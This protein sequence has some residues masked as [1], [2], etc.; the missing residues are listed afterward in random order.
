MQF[1]LLIKGGEV[2]DPGSDRRGQLDVA[3]KR[4]R[5][6]A[7]EA[8]I[9]S[10]SAHR[11]IDATGQY[12]TSGLIDLHTHVYHNVTCWGIL[13][14][15]VAARSGVTTWLDV[16]SAGAYNLMGFREFI[17]KPASA[18]LYALLNISSIGLTAQTWELANLNHCDVDLCCKLIDLNRDLV[19]GVKVRIDVNTTSGTGVEPLHRAQIAA[20]RTG[21]P[22]MVHIGK[23]PPELHEVIRFLR[24]G[25][26]L[27]HCFTGQTMRII[28]DKG[29]LLDDVRRAWDEGVVMDIGHGAGSFS[30]E[31][32]EALIAAGY[33]PDVISSDIHQFSIHG[34]LFDLPTCMSK[35]LALG[36]SF[37]QVVEAATSQPAGVLGMQ[38]EIGTLRP[39]ALADVA[40]FRIEQGNFTFYD[41]HMNERKGKELIRNTLTIVNGRE[42]PHMSDPPPAPWAEPNETQRSL[43]ARGH[44]PDAMVA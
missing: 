42:L 7:V 4:N 24:P 8:N 20:E 35:F 15:P 41:V 14:D 22:M 21:L 10:E 9:P 44:T 33:K 23:G 1:D 17:A 26:I 36:M 29:R 37:A 5:I 30:F 18:R 40:L 16:G 2:V 6:A 13:A 27:T 3:I 34:P 19:L 32:A 12:V 39:G 43:V 11:V 38:Q 31:T 25:D 28:D